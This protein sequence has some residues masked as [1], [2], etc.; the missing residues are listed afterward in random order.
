MG[1][2][3]VRPGV[4]VT[5][6]IVVVG[7][8]VDE[9]I[10]PHES[11]VLSLCS[12][13]LVT[14]ITHWSLQ[15]PLHAAPVQPDPE[16]GTGNHVCPEQVP[17][18]PLWSLSFILVTDHKPLIVLFGPTK[19]TP[20]LA[21]SRLARWA[22]TLSQYQYTIEYRKTCDHSNADALSH[23]PVGPD[24]NFDGEE[25]DADVDTV[26]TIKTV[27]LQLDPTDPGAMAK[28]SAKDPV[29]SNVMSFTHA[30]VGHR[31]TKERHQMMAQW[32]I[33][34]KW[35]YRC[36][37]PMGPPQS[38][39]SKILLILVIHTRIMPLHSPERSSRHGVERG[40]S[41][42]SLVHLTT[43]P[44]MGQ[45]NICCRPSS[46]LSARAA[47]KSQ[48]Q[49]LPDTVTP[50]YSVGSPCYALYC[51]PRRDKDPRWGPAVVTKRFGTQSVNVRVFPR[52]GTWRR[53][54]EQL[55]PCYVDQ[56]DADPGEIPIQ[57][58]VPTV[59]VQYAASTLE[60]APVME[61]AQASTTPFQVAPPAKKAGNPHLRTRNEYGPHNLQ[62]SS[63][64]PLSKNPEFSAF[65]KEGGK[66]PWL[67]GRFATIMTCREKPDTSLCCV[68]PYTAQQM[69]RPLTIAIHH[70]SKAA[71]NCHL[72]LLIDAAIGIAVSTVST[73][74]ADY[75][76]VVRNGLLCFPT[77]RNAG[78]AM[79]TFALALI[80]RKML[81]I[82]TSPRYLLYKVK[83]WTDFGQMIIHSQQVQ[84]LPKQRRQIC[85]SSSASLQHSFTVGMVIYVATTTC[86]SSATTTWALFAT[87]TR[88]S[89]T[90]MTTC[91]YFRFLFYTAAL[92]ITIGIK[93]AFG[94]VVQD[95]CIISPL[96]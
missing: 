95:F 51:G 47:T 35:Q 21:A 10:L 19:A 31:R 83:K 40:E 58:P 34:G 65:K 54:I 28:E 77:I 79:A 78:V 48:E 49:E 53:H 94:T 57:A 30:K 3:W 62:R 45:L 80:K 72:Q 26:C 1:G 84:Y 7:V 2:D 9:L 87:T 13:Q 14:S 55:H 93:F 56:D 22:L 12:P 74:E 68:S 59:S 39:W 33:F 46:R 50:I 70:H 61:M 90:T 25:D 66:H 20:A 11:L 85:R 52:E 63:R 88:A 4:P 24:A 38:Y 82:V 92:F 76:Y 15:Q 8:G 32:R 60:D 44:P 27:S 17:P 73:M 69:W 64:Q 36:P 91:P 29:I 43:L 75:L 41:P 42:I 23:L 89:F 6:D 81:W 67:A 5:P 16:R 71:V 18:V 96:I 86:A 37:Q